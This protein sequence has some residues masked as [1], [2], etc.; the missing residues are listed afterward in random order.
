[1]KFVLRM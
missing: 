1:M